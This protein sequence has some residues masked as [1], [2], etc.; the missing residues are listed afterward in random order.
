MRRQLSQTKRMLTAVGAS[1]AL[2]VLATQGPIATAAVGANAAASPAA[3]PA[4]S[5]P[6][7]YPTPIQHLVVIFQE[8]VSFDH[9]FGTYPD[10]A[11]TSGQTFTK[12]SKTPTGV[13]GLTADLLTKNPNGTNPRRYD[14]SNVSD[15]LTC[16]Q[17]HDYHDEQVAFDNGQ[18]DKFVTSV[19]NGSGK[20]PEG[21]ACVAGDVMNYYDG[22][23]VT[24]LWNYAQRFAMS[25]N[26]FSPTFGPSSPGAINLV[27]GYTGGVDT[28]HEVNSPTIAT[29]DAP[30]ADLQSDGQGGYS[31]IGDAQPYWDDCSTRDAVGKL[32]KNIGDELNNAGLPWGWF[33]GGFRPTTS[34]ADAATAVGQAGQATSTFTPNEFKDA[35]FQNQVLYSSNEGICNAVTPVGIVLGGHG[36]YG[37]KDDTSRT[38][39]RSSTTRAR[40]VRTTSAC[41]PTP[42]ATTRSVVSPRSVT[43]HRP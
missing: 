34:F 11:N 4:A 41:Q 7:T 24:A 26:S 28:A 2:V 31:L 5:T 30:D 32:G 39:S 1:A 19:G 23:T 43:T 42:R 10:A 14:P 40:P 20:S 22:N 13:N 16:D 17:D 6:P 27:S 36:Q 3:S 33:Q 21:A 37:Y 38:T 25:D 29:T 9:Y 35:G 8:N 18:M 12:H 15:L